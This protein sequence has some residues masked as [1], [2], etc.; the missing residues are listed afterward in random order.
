MSE[1]KGSWKEVPQK[2]FSIWINVFDK[3][4]EGINLSTPCP[5]CGERTLHRYYTVKQQGERIL[6]G[7]RFTGLGELWEWCSTCRS[8]A[9]YSVAIPD[10]WYCDLSIDPRELA[11]TP[12]VIEEAL[13]KR[14][15]SKNL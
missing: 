9:R 6:Q 7:N 11:H 2:Y 5:L 12:E 3:S 4:R 13:R 1:A 8:F 15:Q 14:Q 10:W